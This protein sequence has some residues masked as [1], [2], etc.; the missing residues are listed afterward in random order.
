MKRQCH[1]CERHWE[2]V[3]MEPIYDEDSHNIIWLCPECVEDMVANAN[4]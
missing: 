4:G 3:L 1:D 2:K